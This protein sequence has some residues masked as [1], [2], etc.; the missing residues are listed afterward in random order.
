MI[1]GFV[2][3]ACLEFILNEAGKGDKRRN[4][5]TELIRNNWDSI[6]WGRP[7]PKKECKWPNCKCDD[8]CYPNVPQTYRRANFNDWKNV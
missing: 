2:S 6:K 3:I 4:E 1:S 7:E 8:I 5:S